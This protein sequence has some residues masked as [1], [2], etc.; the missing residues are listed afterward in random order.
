MIELLDR[1]GNYVIEGDVGRGSVGTV[2]RARHQIL[3]TAHAIKVLRV[4]D[5]ELRARLVAEGRAQARLDHPNVVRVTDVIDVEGRPGLVM[6]YVPGPSLEAL[7]RRVRPTLSEVERLFRGIVEGVAAAHDAGIVHRDLKPSNILIDKRQRP[8]RPR[9]A[10]FGIA[11]ALDVGGGTATGKVLGTPG[12]MAPEQLLGRS[13]IGPTA[14][15]FSL[16]V[17]LAELL[18]GALPYAY[19]DPAAWLE[20]V[21]SG[22]WQAPDDCPARLARV[23]RACLR[24]EPAERPATAR[25]VLIALDGGE[26]PIAAPSGPSPGWITVVIGSLTFGLGAITAAVGIGVV[27]W[28]ASPVGVERGGEL[29]LHAWRQASSRPAVALALLRAAVAQAGRELPQDVVSDLVARGAAVRVLP[30]PE[31]GVGV[32]VSGEHFAAATVNGAV[33]VWDLR[34]GEQV[35]AVASGLVQPRDLRLIDEPLSFTLRP[36]PGLSRA[37]TD[38]IWWS[39]P[40]G[41]PLLRDPRRAAVSVLPTADGLLTLSHERDRS[42]IRAHRRDGTER[43]SRLLPGHVRGR[44]DAAGDAV[45]AL[46]GREVHVFDPGSGQKVATAEV[47][48]GHRFVTVDPTGD[49]AVVSGSPDVRVFDWARGVVDGGVG[50]AG[51]GRAVFAPDG[52][53]FLVVSPGWH[54]AAVHRGDGAHVTD[55]EGHRRDVTEVRFLDA[56]TVVTGGRDGAVRTFRVGGGPALSTLAGHESYVTALASR[57]DGLASTSLDRTARW[58]TL[59]PTVLGAVARRDAAER[60]DQARA[61]SIGEAV[62]Q[63]AG[64]QVL[65]WY[66]LRDRVYTASMASPEV[67]DVGGSADGAVLLAKGWSDR[68]LRW[69]P[70][71]ELAE[72]PT[73]ESQVWMAVNAR[74]DVLGV[75]N[76]HRISLRDLQGRELAGGPLTGSDPRVAWAGDSLLV[77]HGETGRVD[78]WTIEPPGRARVLDHAIPGQRGVAT[79]AGSPDGGVAIAGLYGGGVAAWRLP[80]G[81][82]IDLGVLREDPI[83]VATDGRWAVA[84]SRVGEVAMWDLDSGALL[85]RHQLRGAPTCLRLAGSVVIVGDAEGRVVWWTPDQ[86][87]VERV[88]HAGAVRALVP[89]PEHDRVWSAGDDGTAWGWPTG[90]VD[91]PAFDLRSTGALTNLRVCRENGEVVPVVPWPD[92]ASIWAPEAACGPDLGG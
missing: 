6:D 10:D 59:P 16:G 43:W 75:A 73:L 24:A 15:V 66:P 41:A 51:T 79:V 34:S 5:P 88:A 64:D 63:V 84:A 70:G 58:W 8:P 61:F 28:G 55:L 48:D 30:L 23:A 71:G 81:E 7:L 40:E 42:R 92:P 21:R 18:S 53:H 77:G 1:I 49:R 14:D 26:A 78:V 69:A 36:H 50:R 46:I 33:Y 83:R 39:L 2:Y 12:Y 20:S 80:G 27:P 38:T 56:A 57:P 91:T 4:D 3:D 17:L 87:A 52:E 68:T 54:H 67:Q 90:M 31:E 9:V 44:W 11:R 25:D 47:G 74:H 86:P 22:D 32:D 45:A 35:A 89:D 72:I 29:E 60:L 65:A 13:G 37:A 76:R 62:V 82:R 19:T 85:G